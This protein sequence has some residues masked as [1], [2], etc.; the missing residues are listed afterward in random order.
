MGTKFSE[1]FDLFLSSIDDY[2]LFQVEDEELDDILCTYL[3]GC[4]GHIQN[5]VRNLADINKEEKCFNVELSIVEQSLVAKAM[6]LE[7]VSGRKYSQELMEKSIGDR[8]YKAVQGTDYLK[9]L[10]QVET[11]LRREIERMSIDY[12]F[13]EE[14]FFGGLIV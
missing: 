13:S 2:E 9:G 4:F 10:S 6:K 5:G 7:W 12:S 11:Q 3:Y 8:D 1:I 14:D